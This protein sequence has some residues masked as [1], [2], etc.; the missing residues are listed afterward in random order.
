M[1]HRVK[2]IHLGRTKS[3]RTMLLKQLAVSLFL[4]E[5]IETTLA[6]AKKL[7]PYAERLITLA[8]EDSVTLRRKAGTKLTHKNAVKKLF[9]VIGPQYKTRAG[10]YTRIRRSYRREGD[11]AEMA[12]IA[13]VK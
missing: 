8:K 12:R 6:K 10:G 5:D 13:L 1:R 7:R 4:Y 2:K 9:E 11:R 3:H